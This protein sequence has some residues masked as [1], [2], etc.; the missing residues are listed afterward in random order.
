MLKMRKTLKE[1]EKR[2]EKRQIRIEDIFNRLT[3]NTPKGFG[4]PSN[5]DSEGK[6]LAI[7]TVSQNI[8]V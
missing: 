4:V 6:I 3:P 1:T 8:N 7:D 2:Y 5:S